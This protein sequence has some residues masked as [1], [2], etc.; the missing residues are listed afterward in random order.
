MDLTTNP[1]A[2]GQ[3]LTQA[4]ELESTGDRYGAIGELEQA[5][6]AS[7]GNPE[8]LLKLSYH[9]DLVGEEEEALQLMEQACA[10]PPA[11]VNALINL[12]ILLEDNGRYAEAE[13][14]L[15]QV[16]DTN[17]NHKRARSFLKDVRASREMFK[18][19]E[20]SQKNDKFSSMMDTPITDFELSVRAR[21]CL[22]KMNIRTLGDLLRTSESELLAYKNFG[23]TSLHEIKAMLA[24]RGL[25][26]GQAKDQS[27]EIRDKVYE[28]LQETVGEE[29][30][31]LLNN[32]V[33][34]LDLSVRARKAL[35]LLNIRT[36]G[37]LIS[38]TEAE[39]MGVKNFGQ[40]SLDEI[41]EKLVSRGLSFRSLDG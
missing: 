12:A 41:K 10:E 40:T 13:K 38:R 8:I 20:Q 24:Q 23:E 9:K 7:P 21:N 16:V 36:I 19:D 4:R 35:D 5:L 18:E 2:T 22:R 15:K 17:P 28:Q 31:G 1:Q 30:L 14:C 33:N 25:R 32:S 39:L 34:E 37:D 29:V 26:I 6:Q 11:R 27:Q 3:H